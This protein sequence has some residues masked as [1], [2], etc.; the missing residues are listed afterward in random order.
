MVK[1]E[2][3]NWHLGRVCRQLGAS[4]VLG[5]P[6]A[7]V[8]LLWAWGWLDAVG[9]IG[10]DVVRSRQQ[11]ARFLVNTQTLQCRCLQIQTERPWGAALGLPDSSGA[12][13]PAEGRV[14]GRKGTE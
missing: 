8:Q 1:E 10:P 6:E 3:G 4:S 14:R 2:G 9:W 13:A 7:L 5:L 12:E 11:N